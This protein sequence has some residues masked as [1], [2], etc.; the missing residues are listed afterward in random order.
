[1]EPAA[2]RQRHKGRCP[3]PNVRK[4]PFLLWYDINLKVTL[5]SLAES[6]IQCIKSSLATETVDLR[7]ER[8]I[9]P[10]LKGVSQHAGEG[11]NSE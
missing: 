7:V 3:S 5:T 9:M 11:N 1:M 6:V 8:E 2:M 10:Q 4:N